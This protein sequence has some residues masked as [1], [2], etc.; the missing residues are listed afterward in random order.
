[1]KR[2]LVGMV[3]VIGMLM[4]AGSALAAS[5][6]FN[7][8]TSLK[9]TASKN[10]TNGLDH[11]R[12]YAWNMSGFNLGASE[13]ITGAY[14]TFTNIKNWDTNPNTLY[15]Y[16]A[17]TS[18]SSPTGCSQYVSGGACGV[19][20]T[21]TQSGITNRTTYYTDSNGTAMF[22]EWAANGV[23][24]L[25]NSSVGSSTKNASSGRT[26]VGQ[27][28]FSGTAYTSSVFDFATV[29]G[30]QVL[31][32]LTTYIG[33]GAGGDFALLLDSDCHYFFDNITLTLTTSAGS[34]VPEPGSIILLSTVLAGVCVGLR[35][36]KAATLA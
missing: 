19:Q 8:D 16:I 13:T 29:G 6:T 22:D 4:P 5:Y 33:S 28:S 10:D 35:K 11:T 36:K 18:L 1:M 21:N 26:K 7:I 34:P 27:T 17:A 32:D 14:L 12:A 23:N 25:Y 24:P 3:A 31:T 15:V 2:S 20:G 30:S 9:N